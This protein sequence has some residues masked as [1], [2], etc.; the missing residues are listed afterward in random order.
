MHAAHATIVIDQ[1]LQSSII[2]RRTDGTRKREGAII[3]WLGHI[4]KPGSSVSRPTNSRASDRISHFYI[5]LP[6]PLIS[7]PF[8]PAQLTRRLASGSRKMAIGFSIIPINISRW[9]GR[10]VNSAVY[11]LEV[12][13]ESAFVSKRKAN[14]ISRGRAYGGDYTSFRHTLKLHPITEPTRFGYLNS[15][16]SRRSSRKT[17]SGNGRKME[18]REEQWKTLNWYSRHVAGVFASLIKLRRIREYFDTQLS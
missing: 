3:L 14:A 2:L 9:S 5:E 10:F 11:T 8:L 4:L 13:D 16:I 7:P 17:I 1:V 15:R 12:F 18:K 6:V